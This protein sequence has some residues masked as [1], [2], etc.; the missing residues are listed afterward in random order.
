MQEELK[1]NEIRI[2]GWGV[3]RRCLVELKQT[4]RSEGWETESGGAGMSDFC[5]PGLKS[6]ESHSATSAA[7]VSPCKLFFLVNL[8]TD[9]F[10]TVQQSFISNFTTTLQNVRRSCYV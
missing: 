2:N 1:G 9:I 5:S 4:W 10:H 8:L 6:T 3:G 7:E